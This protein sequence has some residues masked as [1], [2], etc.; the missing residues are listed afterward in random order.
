[1]N[2]HLFI[3]FILTAMLLA[4]AQAW[5]VQVTKT[6]D[7]GS[8][9]AEV[10]QGAPSSWVESD[11]TS[12]TVTYYRSDDFTQRRISIHTNQINYYDGNDWKPIQL[13]LKNIPTTHPLYVQ[14]YRKYSDMGPLVVVAKPD[15]SSD[16]HLLLLP[17]NENGDWGDMWLKETLEGVGYFDGSTKQDQVLQTTQSSIGTVGDDDVLFQGAFAGTDIRYTLTNLGMKE[18]IV[19]NSKN[20][21]LNHPPSDYGL[22]NSTSWLVWKYDLD[23]GGLSPPSDNFEGSWLD[24]N[25]IKDE[26]EM[27]FPLGFATDNGGASKDVVYRLVHSGGKHTLYAGVKY[28]WMVDDNRAYPVVVDPTVQIHTYE[29]NG[30]DT[31]ITSSDGWDGSGVNMFLGLE[32]GVEYRGL[33]MFDL[34]AIPSGYDVDIATL[35][36]YCNWGETNKYMPWESS[37]VFYNENS[38]TWATQPPMRYSCGTEN[39]VTAVGWFTWDVTEA[40]ENAKE[41][42]GQSNIIIIM[43]INTAIDDMDRFNTGQTGSGEP[44][45]NIGYSVPPPPTYCPEITSVSVDNSLIDRDVDYASSGATDNVRITVRVN[46]NDNRDGINSAY[47]WIYDNQDSHAENDGA[48]EIDNVR[49]TENWAIDENTL[50]FRYSFGL[51]DTIGDDNLG[52]FDVKILVVDNVG[53]ENTDNGDS[54]SLGHKLFTVSDLVVPI[55]PEN[56]ARHVLKVSGTVSRVVGAASA[57]LVTVSD[58]NYGSQSINLAANAYDSSWKTTQNGT[59]TA[60]CL[61]SPLDGENTHAYNFPNLTPSVVSVSSSVPLMDR[62]IDF[63]GSGAV[64]STTITVRVSDQDNRTNDLAGSAQVKFSI[65]DNSDTVLVDNTDIIGTA[66]AV[67]E[68]TIDVTYSF[69]CPNTNT[70]LGT[71]DVAIVAVDNY[72]AENEDNFAGLGYMLF[73]VDDLSS[74]QNVEN[75][76]HHR[77]RT[78]GTASR[79]SGITL[80]SLDS[81]LVVDS[82]DG[83]SN[84]AITGLSWENI[85]YPTSSASFYTRLTGEGGVLDNQTASTSYVWPNFSPGIVSVVVNST[86]IDVCQNVVGSGAVLQTRITVVVED[87]DNYSELA[88]V[89]ENIRDASDVLQVTNENL[90]STTTFENE[91]RAIVYFDLNPGDENDNLG[92]WDVRAVVA[93]NYGAENTNGWQL[94]VF[95]VD[96]LSTTINFNPTNPY[97]GWDLTVSGT[98]SRISGAAA[99]TDSVLLIDENNGTFSLGAGNSWSQTYTITNATLGENVTTTVRIL[100]APLDG[101]YVSS[102]LVNEN[103][104]FEVVVRFEENYGIVGWIPDENRPVKLLFEWDGGT[105]PC[106]LTSNPENII[107]SSDNIAT[108]IVKITDN[109]AYWRYIL[110]AYSGGVLDFV[111][112]DDPTDVDQFT[113]FLQDY[114]G[115]YMPPN[116]QLIFKLWVGSDLAEINSD[117]WG[118]D[119][120]NTAWLV[121]GAQYQIWVRGMNAPLRMV[122]PIDA[123]TPS[124]EKTII[125]RAVISE[126]TPIY[127]HVYWA[128]WQESDTIIR[129]EYQDNLDNTI[130][131]HVGIY[132]MDGDLVSEYQPD[133]EWFI[134]TWPSAENTESYEVVLT[135]QHGIYGDFTMTMPIGL[136]TG[137]PGVE[138]GLSEPF[139]LPSGMTLAALGSIILVFIVGLAFDALRVQLGMLAIVMTTL[140]CWYMG[141][142]PLPGPWDGVFTATLILVMAVLFA[143]TWR[144]GK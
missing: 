93:D 133:N 116:G 62:D 120:R 49:M 85:R 4:T 128:A 14:G 64:E 69:N 19:F 139:N 80:T 6:A 75:L 2:R 31:W 76:A 114:T 104:K 92:G 113:F 90:W 20:V 30:A 88:S 103:G 143:L 99:S 36:L 95:T 100:D 130:E 98:V 9:P 13:E 45:L 18:E 55:T 94:D 112:V 78:Y 91:N 3:A 142:L 111:I 60:R 108:K 135:V 97:V 86:L 24:F 87:N 66:T 54:G 72:S 105:Y 101:K 35:Y 67:D 65:R 82:V 70:N 131:A 96:D 134:I 50:E 129:V 144:R 123:V 117:Y 22:T 12:H 25:N 21:L 109:D 42:T 115:Q 107:V 89:V 79:A 15:I 59:V 57:D 38:G 110:P 77:I 5:M 32:G 84:G 56:Q 41:N 17:R 61:D 106:T 136:A 119:W 27:F 68:N 39:E 48:T 33:Y 118:A 102:Y 16:D 137:P 127:D 126:L 34:S 140:F 63:A 11:R 71:F 73:I 7:A 46:D 138:G 58:S 125:V 132:D 37:Q 51:S 53:K 81:T 29:N 1:M 83:N 43:K 52:T 74:T 122:G 28:D 40:V 23:Y 26:L 121:T 10:F 8:N 44:Y 124:A 141:F 47:I